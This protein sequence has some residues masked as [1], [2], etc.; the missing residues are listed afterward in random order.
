MGIDVSFQYENSYLVAKIHGQYD[1]NSLRKAMDT[2]NEKIVQ[3][4]TDRILVDSLHISAPRNEFDRYLVGLA[5]SDLSRKGL[6]IAILYKPE[7]I[8]RFT[9]NTAVNRGVNLHVFGDE[10]EAL[11]WLLAVTPIRAITSNKF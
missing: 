8:N 6:K 9:E 5:I 11:E 4:G 1:V 2:I 10:A 7:L 3:L